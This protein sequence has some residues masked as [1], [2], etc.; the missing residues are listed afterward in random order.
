MIGISNF[1]LRERPP[2]TLLNQRCVPADHMPDFDDHCG[3]ALSLI[4]T[5][6]INLMS[7]FNVQ[8]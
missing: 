5:K 1:T 4:K 8:I 6:N 7:K 3:N 2:L